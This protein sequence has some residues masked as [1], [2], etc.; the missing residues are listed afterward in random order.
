MD[1]IILEI[2]PGVGGVEANLFAKDLLRMYTRYAQSQKWLI[3]QKNMT[4]TIKGE[5]A[6]DKLKYEA[7]VHRVQ[8]VP[9]TEKSGRIHTSTATVAILNKPK[10]SQVQINPADL[11]IETARGSGPGGQHRN[12]RDTAVRIVHKPS[13]IEAKAESERSQHQ[14]KAKAMEI[15]KKKLN[16]QAQKQI[17]Q[18]QAQTRRKQIGQAERSEKIRTYNFP[19]NRITDHRINKSWQNLDHVIDGNLRKIIQT[20]QKKLD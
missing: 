8:R 15:I 14:N 18:K 9:T 13:G 11:A 20:L 17:K 16:S 10:I 3:S 7:G 1:K 12:T 19:Q 6:F 4:L 5:N 2:R